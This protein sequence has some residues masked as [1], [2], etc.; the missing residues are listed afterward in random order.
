MSIQDLEQYTKDNLNIPNVNFAGL[1]VS[2]AKEIIESLAI[3]MQK[4]PY[5]RNSICSIG[6]NYDINNQYNLFE[7][8]N[9]RKEINWTDFAI[10]E[11]ESMSTIGIGSHIPIIKNGYVCFTTTNFYRYCLW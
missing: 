1:E 7:N 8:S 3:I 5:L 4:Y 10:N 11:G 6:N 9:K 2:T